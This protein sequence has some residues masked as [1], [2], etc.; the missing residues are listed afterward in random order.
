MVNISLMFN[1]KRTRM[2]VRDN[3]VGFDTKEAQK[4]SGGK[5][6]LGLL[7]MQERADLIKADLKID[8]A[9]GQGTQIILRAKSGC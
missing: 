6:S 3:G 9:P 7:S 2:I 8:S 5:G 1:H 4:R